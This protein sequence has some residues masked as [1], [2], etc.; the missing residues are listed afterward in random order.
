M[1]EDNEQVIGYEV[2]QLRVPKKVMDLLR[3]CLDEP[4][5]KYLERSIIETV[6]A[7]IDACALVS[8]E[9]IKEKYGLEEIF[10]VS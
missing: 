9:K 7:D 8:P 10:G 3:D 4:V 5:H 1:A 6:K 2:V